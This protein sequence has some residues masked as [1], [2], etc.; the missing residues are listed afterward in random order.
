MVCKCSDGAC[1]RVVAQAAL[2][3]RNVR[4]RQRD[5]ALR[6]MAEDADPAARDT[7]S[8]PSSEMEVGTEGLGGGGARSSRAQ[9]CCWLAHAWVLLLAMGLGQPR[10]SCQLFCWHQ[11]CRRPACAGVHS[12]ATEVAV[13]LR[14][15]CKM[16]VTS[17]QPAITCKTLRC[18]HRRRGT[19]SGRRPSS[20]W[21]RRRRSRG[22]SPS[23]CP[24]PCRRCRPADAR[25]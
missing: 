17:A 5:P 15:L 19:G 20:G 25:A 2:D 16:S 13:L 8:A 1:R 10:Q 23:G 12:P 4:F 24:A 11:V 18:Y 7:G 6:S 22:P 3:A 21:R 14:W 9:C